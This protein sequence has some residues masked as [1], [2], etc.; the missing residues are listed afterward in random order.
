MQDHGLELQAAQSEGEQVLESDLVLIKQD[1]WLIHDITHIQDHKWY[2]IFMIRVSV[3]LILLLSLL[4][5][6]LL[7][8]QCQSKGWM[9]DA[10]VK[11]P[12]PEEGVDL[13]P[14]QN[15]HNEV[16]Q[17]VT[18]SHVNHS[19]SRLRQGMA[20]SPSSLLGVLLGMKDRQAEQDRP[21][22]TQV[23]ASEAPQDV[24]YAQLNHVSLRQETTVPPS[25]PS[26]EPPVE[27]STL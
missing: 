16:P 15:R 9:S 13:N 21:M 8:H 4:L 24:T 20:T 23:A 14:Q 25:S 6:L 26:E 1:L 11:D 27:P 22:D 19:G 10:V 5:F 17:E 7:R 3:A 2:L 12:Q 18:Y